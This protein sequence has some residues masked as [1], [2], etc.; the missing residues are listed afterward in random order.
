MAFFY[1][2][3]ASSL[4]IERN[5]RNFQQNSRLRN[6]PYS[7]VCNIFILLGWIIKG[8]KNNSNSNKKT[9]I[10]CDF[11]FSK[12]GRKYDRKEIERYDKDF[13][14]ELVRMR[15]MR[16]NSV[17]ADCGAS[18]S[19]WASVNF[20]VYLC[21]HCAQVHRSLGSSKVKSTMGT[22]LW[23]PDEMECM[24]VRGNAWAREAYGVGPVLSHRNRP[25]NAA[26][27]VRQKYA[28]TPR[29]LPKQRQQRQSR[30]SIA[31]EDTEEV[32]LITFPAEESKTSSTFDKNDFFEEWLKDYKINK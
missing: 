16:E 20:G 2:W 29:V 31:T 6:N 13:H 9:K 26:Q 11:S 21:I 1:F 7:I 18:D 24:R 23:H 27:I 22:Y 15:K 5:Q 28:H 4:L 19:T 25:Q 8:K 32:N 30:A 12:F 17:C 10:M 14:R 3:S